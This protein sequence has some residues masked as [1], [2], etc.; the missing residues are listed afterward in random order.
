MAGRRRHQGRHH[1]RRRPTNSATRRPSN[2]VSPND[3]QATLLHLFGMDHAKLAYHYNGQEQKLT[4]GR[5]SRVVSDILL[6]GERVE[7]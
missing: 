7:A 3:Y 1:L 2:T 6:D 4:D 5:P